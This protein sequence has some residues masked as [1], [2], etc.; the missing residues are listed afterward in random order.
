[1]IENVELNPGAIVQEAVDIVQSRARQKGIFVTASVGPDVPQVVK[2][3]PTRIR[4]I[5]LNLL[6]NAVKFTS[7]GGVHVNMRVKDWDGNICQM[8]VSVHDS[9]KGFQQSMAAEL[10]QPFTQDYKRT[11]EDFEGTGLG[12]SICKSLVDTFG[13]EI[14]CEGVP[15]E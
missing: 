4:Q 14:K 8:L 12:L 2:G 6:G 5:L 7:E 9:G 11:I 10:F 3:D 15:G 13:G 1:T